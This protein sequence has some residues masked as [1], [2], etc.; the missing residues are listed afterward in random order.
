MQSIKITIADDAVLLN[1]L[2]QNNLVCHEIA[3]SVGF[4]HGTARASC[5]TNGENNRL[6]WWEI[7]DINYK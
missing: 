6:A 5:M 7:R 3:H 2:L 4:G 1:D